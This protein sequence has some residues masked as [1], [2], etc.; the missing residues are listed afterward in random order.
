[1]SAGLLHHLLLY[2]LFDEVGSEAFRQDVE[3]GHGW[4]LDL[5]VILSLRFATTAT[6]QIIIPGSLTFVL[7]LL[8]L[9]GLGERIV[10]AFFYVDDACGLTE[11]VGRALHAIKIEVDCGV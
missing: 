9:L 10:E 7:L 3:G 4:Q 11:L 5:V 1:M 8:R 2:R 6:A